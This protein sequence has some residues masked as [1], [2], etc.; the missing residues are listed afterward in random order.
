MNKYQEA[1]DIKLEKNHIIDLHLDKFPEAQEALYKNEEF[2]ENINKTEEFSN[3]YH[4]CTVDAL[5]ELVDKA[6]PKKTITK[7]NEHNHIDRHCPV[8]KSFVYSFDIYC[9]KCGQRIRSNEE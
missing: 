1:L 5:Q 6:T 9:G 3:K 7:M 4:Q 2:K 8:C